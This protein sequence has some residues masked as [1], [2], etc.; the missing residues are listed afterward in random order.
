MMRTNGVLIKVCGFCLTLAS[1]ILI[2][3]EPVRAAEYKG[4]Y[5]T[6]SYCGCD[7]CCGNSIRKLTYSGERPTPEHTVAANLDIFPLGSKL[8]I[9]DVE[10]M[11]E[12]KVGSDSQEQIRIYFDSHE[13]AI[14]YGRKMARVSVVKEEKKKA[15]KNSLGEF[16]VTAYC[17]CEICCG[18]EATAGK[19]YSGTVPKSGH[20]VAADPDLLPIGARIKINDSVYTVEDTGSEIKGKKLDIYF[21]NHEEAVIFGRKTLDVYRA[22]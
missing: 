3:S 19:T 10:Y 2:S 18:E 9:D 14:E 4:E 8:L 20:T 17:S 12:D 16:E 11:V 5:L 21:D 7:I 1:G 6:A 13:A 22:D 15:E